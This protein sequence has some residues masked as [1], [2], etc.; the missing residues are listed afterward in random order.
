MSSPS[1]I[2]IKRIIGTKQINIATEPNLLKT[3]LV[4]VEEFSF[5]NT[6]KFIVIFLKV[7]LEE[8]GSES[9]SRPRIESLNGDLCLGVRYEHHTFRCG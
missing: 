2:L 6:K 7:L 1:V 9:L 8:T 4:R 5:S 3:S